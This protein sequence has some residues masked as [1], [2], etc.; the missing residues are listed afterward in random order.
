MQDGSLTGWGVHGN[1]GVAGNRIYQE[2][3]AEVRAPT[4][5]WKPGSC[6]PGPAT[7]RR[8]ESCERLQPLESERRN[9]KQ[10]T[11]LGKDG[12]T[13]RPGSDSP[14]DNAVVFIDETGTGVGAPPSGEPIDD[15]IE[16]HRKASKLPRAGTPGRPKSRRGEEDP[17]DN[18]Q[19]QPLGS[20]PRPCTPG[21]RV[22]GTPRPGSAQRVPG[23]PRRPRTPRAAAEQPH[24][25]WASDDV[26]IA[27]PERTVPEA[28]SP[29]SSSTSS[30]SADAELIENNS[31][32]GNT[33]VAND[34]CNI[35]IA[36]AVDIAVGNT[37]VMTGNVGIASAKPGVEIE[38]H[39]IAR[40]TAGKTDIPTRTEVAPAATT[41]REHDMQNTLGNTGA[42]HQLC[43]D[44]IDAVVSSAVDA[45]LLGG[46]NA[47]LLEDVEFGGTAMTFAGTVGMAN[48]RGSKFAGTLGA[49]GD[50]P[51]V[52]GE[53]KI[54]FGNTLGATGNI[55]QVEP[56]DVIPGDLSMPTTPRTLTRTA[57]MNFLQA[58]LGNEDKEP[59]SPSLMSISHHSPSPTKRDLESSFQGDSP[60]I[61]IL[62][63]AQWVPC[64]PSFAPK[65][66][67]VS[68][69]K[70]EHVPASKEERPV[71]CGSPA[72]LSA[73]G[74]ERHER[75]MA[76]LLA[77][78]K[79]NVRGS[80]PR[81]KGMRHL[82]VAG[83][84]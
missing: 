59:L 65:D 55:P 83:G 11:F 71:R 70:D 7:R 46:T 40:I 18:D 54:T 32:L 50:V 68:A 42:A 41:L 82:S 49:T 73:R 10:V 61:V 9:S 4:G 48:T 47:S 22:P 21:M 81:G 60:S 37:A 14:I 79:K 35:A 34:L 36:A 75:E 31:P 57:T 38:S 45:L 19:D 62:E 28:R 67:S 44:A 2:A 84:A 78:G 17:F 1:Q 74:R 3:A 27:S 69:S 51:P 24:N 66:E 72:P 8:P 80:R 77:A 29:D 5:S 56:G 53:E 15:A 25:D 23:T 43:S 63:D 20:P 26:V 64:K 30:C 52:F 76:A 12:L 39:A 13:T 16:E 33:G 6:R 58:A